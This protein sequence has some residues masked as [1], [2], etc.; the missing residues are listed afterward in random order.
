MEENILLKTIKYVLID[1]MWFR[2][3]TALAETR[4]IDTLRCIA[5]QES[6]WI[7]ELW[8]AC[9]IHFKIIFANPIIHTDGNTNLK[10]TV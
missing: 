7:L 4:C 10:S 5:T 3:T 9:I 1:L 6:F 8:K 2:V